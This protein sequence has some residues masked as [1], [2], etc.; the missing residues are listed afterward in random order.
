ME[1]MVDLVSGTFAFIFMVALYVVSAVSLQTIGNKTGASN[2]WFAWIPILN[3]VLLLDIAGMDLWMIILFFIP[4]VNWI[5]LGYV[6][7]QIAAERGKSEFIGWLMLVPIVDLFIP[8]YLA[9][10]D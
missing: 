4:C 10:S 5:F 6:W 9:F 2:T 1:Q 3:L 8:P 7:S